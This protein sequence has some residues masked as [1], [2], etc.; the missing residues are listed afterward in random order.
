MELGAGGDIADLVNVDIDDADSNH[1]PR[2]LSRP[3]DNPTPHVPQIRAFENNSPP[4]PHPHEYSPPPPSQFPQ[5]SPPR[6]PSTAQFPAHSHFGSQQPSL[7]SNLQMEKEQAMPLVATSEIDEF[8]TN[9]YD[10]VVAQQVQEELSRDAAVAQ[11]VQDSL[12]RAARIHG[13][14]TYIHE[15]ELPDMKMGLGVAAAVPLR[16]AVPTRQA[17]AAN[18]GQGRVIDREARSEALREMGRSENV[19]MEGWS[20]RRLQ[21]V[22]AYAESVASGQS[23]PSIHESRSGNTGS[24]SIKN[25]SIRDG[26]GSIRNGSM[27]G[28]GGSIKE[29]EIPAK[30][31]LRADQLRGNDQRISFGLNNVIS[32]AVG[33]S[34]GGSSRQ[35]YQLV[36]DVIG[37]RSEVPIIHAPGAGQYRNGPPRKVSELK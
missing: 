11:Q 24:G 27:R 25:G 7:P 10:A 21:T 16:K 29:I 3:F 8:A 37:E 6:P 35:R 20:P 33:M 36:D 13:R 15:G 32:N 5:F 19:R 26:N 28:G 31:P 23:T 17:S 9:W 18:M 12:A 34:P 1:S 22:R 30:S 14:D 2:S 4:P